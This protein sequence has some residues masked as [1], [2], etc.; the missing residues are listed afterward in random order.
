MADQAHQLSRGVKRERP[1]A[2]L[3]FQTRFLRSSVTFAV[4]ARV[5]GRD[6]VLPRRSSST[7]SRQDMVQ[8]QLRSREQIAA[9]LARVPI[10]Q[11]DVFPRKR[12]TLLGNMPVAQQANHR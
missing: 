3:E 5:A 4:V 2:A 7:R 6:E 9:E 1:G 12:A 8:R 11:Q 10:A